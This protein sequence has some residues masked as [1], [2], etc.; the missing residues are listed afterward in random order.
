MQTHVR[1]LFLSSTIGACAV[2][3]SAGQTHA[4]SPA[5][6]ST[7]YN[8]SSSGTTMS[9]SAGYKG[10]VMGSKIAGSHVKNK[11]H[12]ELGTIT[13]VVVNPDTGHI[14]FAVVSSGGRSVSVPW[15]ALD[16]ENVSGNQKP[17]FVLDTTKQKLQ[18]APAFDSSKLSQLFTRTME[19]PVFTYYDIIWFPDVLTP[20]ERGARSKNQADTTGTPGTGMSPDATSTPYSTS[21]PYPTSTP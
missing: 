5:A 10:F 6:T 9:G 1:T 20:E 13:D 4:Q 14:R 8:I 11:Q 21:T 19:E 16:V 2:L 15:S 3:L 7:P 17:V 12:V 18:K